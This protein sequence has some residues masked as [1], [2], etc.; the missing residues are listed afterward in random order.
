[1]NSLFGL[2]NFSTLNNNIDWLESLASVV[3]RKISKIFL[4]TKLPK[5]MK[6]QLIPYACYAWKNICF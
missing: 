4:M 3:K 1:M 2:L 5:Y 6:K